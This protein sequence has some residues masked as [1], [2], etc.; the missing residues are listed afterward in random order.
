MNKISSGGKVVN[1]GLKII[2][3]RFAKAVPD[4]LYPSTFKVGIGT[5]TATITDTDLEHAIP[6]TG[7][8]AV[9]SCDTANWTDG[10]NM[11]STL[12]TT[13]FKE[14]TGS[15]NFTKDGTGA[16]VVEMHKTTT[17]VDFTSKSLSLWVYIIDATALAKL[18]ATGT[19]ACSIRFGSDASNYYE[20][21]YDT[22]DLAVGWNLL[23]SMTSASADNTQ[24]SPALAAMD[25]SYIEFQSTASATVWSAGDYIMDDWK[26][27]STG[28]FVKAIESGYPTINETTKQVT[29]RT[30][31]PTTQANGYLI[32]EHAVF[33]ED[34]TPL[35]L[36]HDIF[37][38]FSKSD[39]DELIFVDKIIFD[40][41]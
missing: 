39:T 20:W 26:V 22:T 21:E 33:N 34:A 17:S 2:M 25:Y 11:T 18:V 40:N 7:T 15:L 19:P 3:N 41:S 23:D 13:T 27:A 10:A 1:N 30:R 36:S 28:D 31:L 24:G 9:D 16:A 12:N 14:G 35:M 29:I 5:T 32:S 38:A 6:I 4:Y 37:S 8:E